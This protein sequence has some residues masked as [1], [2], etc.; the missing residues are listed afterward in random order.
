MQIEE[1][2]APNSALKENIFSLILAIVNKEPIFI[3]GKPGSKL[4]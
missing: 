2:I 3:C 4:I 1:G